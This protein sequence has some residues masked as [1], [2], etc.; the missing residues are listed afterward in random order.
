MRNSLTNDSKITI[1]F[2]IELCNVIER[3]QFIIPV[4]CLKSHDFLMK[5]MYGELNLRNRWT[6]EIFNFCDEKGLVD[7]ST[8]PF[9]LASLTDYF[10]TLYIIPLSILVCVNPQLICLGVLDHPQYLPKLVSNSK[11]VDMG[12]ASDF[13]VHETFLKENYIL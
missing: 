7:Y 1:F 5:L 12:Y 11:V 8:D 13:I 2:D 9:F 6:D 3:I 10:K 4:N